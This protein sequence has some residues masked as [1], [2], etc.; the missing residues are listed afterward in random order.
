MKCKVLAAA[1][2]YDLKRL[3]KY[4]SEKNSFINSVKNYGDLVIVEDTKEGEAKHFCFFSYGIIVFW[5]LSEE[6]CQSYYAMA[7]EFEEDPLATFEV[8]EF[9]FEYGPEARITRRTIILPSKDALTKIAVS[10]ALAQSA[11]LSV[12]E[13]TI[14]HTIQNSQYIPERISSSGR[15]PLSLKEIRIRMA[16]I[17]IDRSSINLHYDLLDEPEFFW[18]YEELE[19]IYRITAKYLDIQD[20]TYV[21]NQ[22]LEVVGEL[23]QMLS[24]EVNHNHSSRLEWIIIWLIGIEILLTLFKDLIHFI[25]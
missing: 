24:E 14:L 5:D 6:A 23:Y 15:Q 4:F 9:A 16:R 10:H 18:D 1:K 3:E 12:F 17:Y 21:L 22:K 2:K 13:K 8:E 7:K 11:K 20:R 19:P 25:Y